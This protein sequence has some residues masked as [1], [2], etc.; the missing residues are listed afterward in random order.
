MQPLTEEQFHEALP[1]ALRKSVSI[2]VMQQINQTISDPEVQEAFKE[3]LLSYT[4]VLQDGRFKLTGYISAV[5]YVSHKLMGKSN[6]DAYIA[7]FPDKYAKFKTQ[8][9]SRKD[10]S[11][12]ASA[13]NKSKLV[14]LIY[15][16]TLIPTHVLNAS[17]FQ[18]AINTQAE[19]MLYAN[20]EKVRSDAAAC[21][22]K[23]LKPPETAKIELDLGQ[24]ADKSIDALRAATQELVRQQKELIKQ[25]A[26][27]KNIAEGALI[28][29]ND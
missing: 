5:K 21:L 3:N 1:P 29:V 15:E 18:K 12:Y 11:S 23:E 24:K 13:F 10:I 6:I 2:D 25:G 19:L 14:N 26:S 22:I 28:V 16:Q 20:S 4:N 27:I 7:T 17:L 8:G 9:V